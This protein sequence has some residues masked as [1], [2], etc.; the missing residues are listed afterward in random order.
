MRVLVTGA[1]GFVGSHTVKS[2]KQHGHNVHVLVRSRQKAEH[3]FDKIGISVD[4]IV[5]GSITD[6]RSILQ[7][8]TGCD[9]VVHAAAL[10]PLPG[11]SAD[12]VFST[13]VDGVKKVMN[14]ALALGIQRIVHVSSITAIFTTD[15]GKLNENTEPSQSNHPYGQS[16]AMAEHYVRKLQKEGRP[17]K[18]IYPAGIIGPDDPGFSAT[19]YALKYRLT[20]GFRVT[21]GGTQQIDVRDLAEIIVRLLESEPGPGRYLTAGI[22]QSWPEFAD[23]LENITGQPLI[24]KKIPG[25]LLRLIGRFYDIKRKFKPVALPI[26]AE[27]MRYATQWPIVK[28][29]P[30]IEK[31]G[32]TLRDPACTFSDTIRWLCDT[33]HLDKRFL[34][35]QHQ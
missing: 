16:K 5:E 27:T 32:V 8:L 6:E 31:L 9:A 12:D 22:Y 11:I 18:V 15:A 17:V 25:W 13:N 23:L 24:R 30:V 2:L 21:S 10:T 7:A 3:W 35:K 34:P 33:G 14:A 19:V 26:S 28:N 20:E 4:Q 29:S 1:T